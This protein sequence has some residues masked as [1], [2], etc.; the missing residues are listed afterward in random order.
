MAA[1]NS[2][3]QQLTEFLS[4]AQNGDMIIFNDP[5]DDQQFVQF[6]VSADLLLGEVGS[7]QWGGDKSRPLGRDAER[8]L[9]L[10]G[11]TDGGPETNYFRDRLPRNPA[12]L[13]KLT[14]QLFQ[15]A[16]G[17]QFKGFPVVTSTV[18]LG[19]MARAHSSAVKKVDRRPEEAPCICPQPHRDE[20]PLRTAPGLAAR[21]WRSLGSN[22]MDYCLHGEDRWAFRDAVEAVSHFDDLPPCAKGWN[23]KSEEGPLAVS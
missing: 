5:V 2:F 10:P 19:S 20:P 8:L 6:A 13:A 11:F 3:D 14:A 23:H 21:A 4:R 7:R 1:H 22:F 17:L 12:A 18:D 15:Q 9:R 16:Y